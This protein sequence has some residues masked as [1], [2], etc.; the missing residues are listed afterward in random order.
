MLIPNQMIEMTWTRNKKYYLEKGYEYTG[1]RNIF[2]VKAEDLPNGS[3]KEVQ[4]KCDCCGKIKK[5]TWRDYLKYH[6]KKFGDLCINC[7]GEK[8][9]NTCQ[10]KY[11]VDN[12]SQVKEFQDKRKETH[13]EKYGV[14]NAFQSE[15][16]KEKIKQINL[17]KYGCECISQVYEVREKIKSTNLEKYGVEVASQCEIIKEKTAQTNL[18]KYGHKSSAQGKEQTKKRISTNLK[19]YGYT[20]PLKN[21]EVKEKIRKTNL[22]KYGFEYA[23]QNPQVKQKARNSAFK[24]GTIPTSKTEKSMCL[25]LKEIYGEQNCIEGYPLDMINFDCLVMFNGIKIDVEYDGEFWH[26]NKKESDRKRNGFVINNGYKVLRIKGNYE[27]PTKK[28]IIDAIDY[29]VKDNHKYVE[30]ILDIKNI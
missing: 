13:I 22:E 18:K 6:T 8:R 19:K 9:I 20:T 28:Q 7:V 26:K 27:I 11:G 16:V 5:M 12:P 4:V 24:N 15:E 23:I 14:E 29:L 30:I 1:F 25:I 3:K 17:E 10:E 21:K 2:L